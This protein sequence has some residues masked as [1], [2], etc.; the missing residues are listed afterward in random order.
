MQQAMAQRIVAEGLSVRMVEAIL[1]ETP[2]PP[3]PTST[4]PPVGSTAHLKDL[5]HTFTR[6]LGMKVQIRASSTKGRG[7]LIIQYMTL[8]EFDSLKDRL[9]IETD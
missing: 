1:S 4:R 3:P 9:G 2:V 7:K 6:Q 8:D 5:E